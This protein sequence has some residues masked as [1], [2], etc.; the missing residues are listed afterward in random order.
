MD[1]EYHAN[2][3]NESLRFRE[4][5]HCSFRLAHLR[6][7]TNLLLVLL[8]SLGYFSLMRRPGE[9]RAWIRYDGFPTK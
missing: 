5:Q 1:H 2:N 8:L 9:A 3:N 4:S 6:Q 7:A